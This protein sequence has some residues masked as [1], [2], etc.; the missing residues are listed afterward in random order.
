MRKLFSMMAIAAAIVV[1]PTMALA[2]G[3]KDKDKKGRKGRRPDAKSLF[4]R[5]DADK[6]GKITASELPER[7]KKRLGEKLK[8]ADT[9]GDGKVCKDEFKAM[10]KSRA[11]A[12]KAKRAKGKK[13]GAKAKRGKG[14]KDRPTA[15]GKQGPPEPDFKAIFA[16]L[17][18]NGDKKLCIEEFTA[19]AKKMHQRISA[20]MRRP[21]AARRGPGMHRPGMHSPAMSGPERAKKILE[22]MEK[23]FDAADKNKDGKVT[24]EEAPEKMK[25]RFGKLLE[26]FDTDGDK[27]LTKEEGKKF[28]D[29][30]IK[31]FAKAHKGG[32][33]KPGFH[34]PSPE[35]IKKIRAKMEERFKA[36]DKDGDGK[37]SKEEVPDHLKAHFEK[38]DANK[39]GKLC[40]E[41]LKKAFEARAKAMGKGPRRGPKGPGGAKGPGSAKG[42]CDSKDKDCKKDKKAK[43][44]KKKAIPPKPP[45]S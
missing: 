26:R 17:D 10:M 19:G 11:E 21:A 12:A 8:K 36:A 18:T 6:D 13:D 4:D 15:K 9:N 41:E 23:R 32:P 45:K 24:L 2:D 44:G 14:K 1:L 40:K 30:M 29:E 7:L 43:G 27:A 35:M 28:A 33:G 31:K 3:D 42:A 34:K 38:I 22:G 16:R 37:L 39:D 25:E 5:L 20:H